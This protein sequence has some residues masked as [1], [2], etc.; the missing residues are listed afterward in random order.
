[1]AKIAGTVTATAG[2]VSGVV[3]STEGPVKYLKFVAIGGA[4]G[5]F[6]ASLGEING[7]LQRMRCVPGTAGDAPSGTMT[8]TLADGAGGTWS[9]NSVSASAE[10]SVFETIHLAGAPVLSINSNLGNGKKA[11]FILYFGGSVGG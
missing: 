7:F 3:Q 9:N 2:S 8:V 1:M 4:D 11:T 10:S 6:S 5:T